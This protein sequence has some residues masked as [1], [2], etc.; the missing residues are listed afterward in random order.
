MKPLFLLLVLAA[1]PAAAVV[2]IFTVN[3]TAD[4]VD[5]NPG[6]GVCETAAGNH[7][8]T[9]RAAIMEANHT[10]SG[11][12]IIEIP[13]NPNPYV[14]TLPKSGINHEA[15]GDLWITRDTSIVGDGPAVSILDGGGIDD[16]LVVFGPSTV[17]IDGLTIRNGY[18]GPYSAGAILNGGHLTL[19]ACV[20][21]ENS[22]A[23]GG[24]IFSNGGS[25]VL[26]RCTGSGNTAHGTRGTGDRRGGGL[27]RN[28]GAGAFGHTTVSGDTGLR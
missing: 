27:L 4:G 7:V 10:V 22:G 21:K 3:T 11:I 26:D 5:A 19:T 18:H 12:T 14:L 23:D 13:G 20:I 6:N 15:T 8:C 1:E 25:L 9:G 28:R 2:H 16:V 24:G 17:D